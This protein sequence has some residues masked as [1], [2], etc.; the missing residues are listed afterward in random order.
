MTPPLHGVDRGFESHRAHF[1]MDP[2][3]EQVFNRAFVSRDDLGDAC[4]FLKASSLDDIVHHKQ[5]H[6]PT[7]DVG[8]KLEVCAPS[9]DGDKG[10]I[11][12]SEH[13]QMAQLTPRSAGYHQPACVTQ[14]A[15]FRRPFGVCSDHAHDPAWAAWPL[16]PTVV[17]RPG[18]ASTQSPRQGRPTVLLRHGRLSIAPRLH[19]GQARLRISAAIVLRR[20]LEGRRPTPPGF[21]RL[22][23]SPFV[24]CARCHKPRRRRC[25]SS[26]WLPRPRPFLGTLHGR[27]TPRLPALRE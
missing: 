19:R 10:A 7:L 24:R 3:P 16:M 5:V 23:R 18:T 14:A 13:R 26:S 12:L 15:P 2:L 4:R 25:G 21:R 8:L 9:V 17:N 1:S 11:K 27:P 22:L 6:G 20:R